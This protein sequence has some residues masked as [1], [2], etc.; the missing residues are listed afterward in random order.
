MPAIADSDQL[1]IFNCD[2]VRDCIDYKWQ[3][4]ARI[5][6]VRGLIFH[7]L[8]IINLSMYI[9]AEYLKQTVAER[10]PHKG[11][12]GGIAVCLIYPL[13]YD[14]TQLVKQGWQVYFFSESSFWNYIDM[15]HIVLGYL[16]IFL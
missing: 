4:F 9:R 14:G 6:H 12:L 10:V 1:A 3:K 15:L 11:L 13:L 5:V 7:T 2:V 8:Y 16:N